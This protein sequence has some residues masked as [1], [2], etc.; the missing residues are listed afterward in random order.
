MPTITI[1][2][3]SILI[4]IFGNLKYDNG[5]RLNIF[6]Y[7]VDAVTHFGMSENSYDLEYPQL[8][9]YPR[10]FHLFSGIGMKIFDS[11]SSFLRLS[12]GKKLIFNLN[13]FALSSYF[14]FAL[15]QI[16]FGVIIFYYLREK[17]K[18]SAF[19]SLLLFFLIFILSGHFLEKTFTA[20]FFPQIYQIAIILSFFYFLLRFNRKDLVLLLF[21]WP[22]F[23]S[24]PF[25]Y[26]MFFI[27]Y[28]LIIFKYKSNFNRLTFTTTI[29]V[30][31][32]NL[33][34]GLKN[35]IITSNSP[36]RLFNISGG[37]QRFSNGDSMILIL[38][39]I[40]LIVETIF[41][42]RQEEKNKLK[43]EFYFTINNLFF[44]IFTLLLF[45]SQKAVY[46]SYYKTLNIFS[47]FIIFLF[48][49]LFV[50]QY[51]SKNFIYLFVIIIFSFF[52]LGNRLEL[53]Y[54]AAYSFLSKENYNGIVILLDQEK[55]KK[56]EFL[57]GYFSE[58]EGI[59]ANAI[60][61]RK[62]KT[63]RDYLIYTSG[64]NTNPSAYLNVLKKKVKETNGNMIIYDPFLYFRYTCQNKIFKDLKK[65]Y[66]K[67]K[68][69]PESI[70]DDHPICLNRGD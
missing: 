68:F 18:T 40:F 43:N 61:N 56:N 44:Y 37:I 46:Y 66:P 21:S 47:F 29:L 58:T 50:K 22:V 32:F 7:G 8:L 5:K 54:N 1:G 10:S 13:F 27:A 30:I 26:P 24:Y 48:F 17:G 41:S 63:D 12:L 35:F 60:L 65:K 49:V 9:G 3:L 45:L 20:G 51:N 52:M 69:Y 15:I 19:E 36:I 42:L 11:L 31:F 2:I 53:I 55:Y 6:T 28:L 59:I 25:L 23:E 62:F 14:L 33:V 64:Y 34:I 39:S 16:I 70:A 57:Y 38:V 67:I 4:F